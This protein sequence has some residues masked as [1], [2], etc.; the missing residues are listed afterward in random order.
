VKRFR[1]LFPA[2]QGFEEGFLPFAPDLRN[3]YNAAL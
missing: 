3:R 2:P 1:A